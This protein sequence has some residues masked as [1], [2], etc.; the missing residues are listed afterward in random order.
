MYSEKQ[1]K[2]SKLLISKPLNL[3]SNESTTYDL[4]KKCIIYKGSYSKD[5][6]L[7][8]TVIFELFPEMGPRIQ[9]GKI[10]NTKLNKQTNELYSTSIK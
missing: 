10:L 2:S 6:A 8:G 9:M 4:S 5:F 7:V 3:V 1:V